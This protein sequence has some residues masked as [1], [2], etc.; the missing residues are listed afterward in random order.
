MILL[1]GG[2]GF[3]GS[4]VL[5]TLNARGKDDVLIVDVLGDDGRY[6]NI[7]KHGFT[8]IIDPGNLEAFLDKGRQNIDAV[9]H[10]GAISSTL[11]QDADKIYTQNVRASRL[12]WHWCTK[13]LV[14]LIYASSAATYGDG[15]L[16][17]HDNLGVQDNQRY[18]PLN[19]YGWSKHIFDQFCLKTL[20]A[21]RPCPP[22]WFGLKFFN[23]YGPNEYHKTGQHSVAHNLF[24]Q[25]HQGENAR[26]FKS[27]RPDYEDGG[28]LRDFVW[29]QDCVDVMLWLL[30]HPELSG[31]L[32][33]VGSGQARSFNDLARAVFSSMNESPRIDYIDMPPLLRGAYQYKTCADLSTLRSLG[34]TKP[35]TSL[36]D[37]IRTYIQE[38]LMKGD[39]YR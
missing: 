10:L 25:I 3:I 39:R 20:E 6:R 13:H 9:I 7:A 2:V 28:Q 35:M 11:E 5:A 19:P 17:F 15:H 14:P 31:M 16:G 36:E 4:H 29:V 33:N 18:R 32:L 34:Y 26:L 27:Y 37:G 38:Y 23:V 24:H 30:D 12:L 8:D 21:S 1:T 22:Q